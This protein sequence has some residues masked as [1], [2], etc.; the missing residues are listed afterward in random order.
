MINI[1]IICPSEIALRRFLPA[2]SKL[3]DFFRFVGVAIATPEEWFGEIS[4]IS[5]KRIEEQQE[6]ELRKAI[7]FTEHYGGKVFKG[8][9]TM[10]KSDLIDA[11]YIPL[12]P[13]LHFKWAKLSLENQKHVF[14]EKPSTTHYKDTASLIS[15]AEKNS[16]ALH[17]NYMFVFHKQ[18]QALNEVVAE[19]KIGVPRLYRISFGFPKRAPSDFRYNKMLGGGALL[20]AGGYT[21]KYASMLL[22]S[23]AKLTTAQVNYSKEFD[24]DIFGSATMV[25]DEGMTAQLAFGM[26]N[27][28]MC[29]IEIWGSM[30]TISSNRILTAPDGF[31]PKYKLKKNQDYSEHELP[32]DDAF[33]K[34]LIRF[35]DCIN[36]DIYRKENYN[37]LLRQAHLMQ[38]FKDMAMTK[39][40]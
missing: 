26:D 7:K 12:P 13:A 38:Q 30:G 36:F 5:S 2:L 15:I 22:G 25:N 10:I 34:S 1:G 20:D 16:L 40:R 39:T 21:I 28:Y 17:E 23:T 35:F 4:G 18:I 37:I 11:I 27:D 3:N 29:N 14:V 31:K 24:V 9:E 8:Y 33:K 32:E 6:S 19:G